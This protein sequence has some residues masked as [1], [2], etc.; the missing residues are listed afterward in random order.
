[1]AKVCGPLLYTEP[2]MHP[3]DAWIAIL[4]HCW[5]SLLQNLWSTGRS[6]FHEIIILRY[7]SFHASIFPVV[8]FPCFKT[9][10]LV[11]TD[12]KLSK[13]RG[14]CNN[15]D[16]HVMFPHDKFSINVNAA[17]GVTHASRFSFFCGS[18]RSVFHLYCKLCMSAFAV[19]VWF[20]CSAD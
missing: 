19:W 14:W 16:F 20:C 1:M 6:V 10:L 12:A 18:Y 9:F 15:S 5:A 3:S 4:N 7:L 17:V 2:P 11:I 13:L 8:V